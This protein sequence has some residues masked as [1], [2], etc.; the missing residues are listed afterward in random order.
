MVVRSPMG[1]VSGAM[2]VVRPRL[3]PAGCHP[4]G[5]PVTPCITALAPLLYIWA[6][7]APGSDC[8][9]IHQVVGARV[10]GARH[11]A[12]LLQHSLLP[13]FEPQWLSRRLRSRECGTPAAPENGFTGTWRGSIGAGVDIVSTTTTQSDSVISGTGTIAGP[14]VMHVSVSGMSE[15]PTVHLVL[16]NTGV[17]FDF[18][19]T[20]VTA[21]SV[22]GTVNTGSGF[23]V[24]M[25]LRRQ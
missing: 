24:P 19:G 18:T 21:D 22:A 15:R 5:G 17:E 9:T 6:A 2:R 14:S 13:R 1:G 25:S 16:S 8:D 7:I 3:R 4:V 23:S 12:L 20:Y 11:S 10:R